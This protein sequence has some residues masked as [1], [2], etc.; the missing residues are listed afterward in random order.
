MTNLKI[1]SALALTS[2]L[3]ACGGEADRKTPDVVVPT[4]TPTEVP[5]PTEPPVSGDHI[6]FA[7]DFTVSSTVD[8]YDRA[9]KELTGDYPEEEDQF[10]FSTGGV[11]KDGELDPTGGNWITADN[12]QS[13]RLGN[14]RFSIAQPA[15]EPGDAR[16][17]TS[18]ATDTSTW[19]EL[20]LSQDYRLSFCVVAGSE[21]SSG[22][23]LFQLYIDNNSTSSSASIHGGASRV[24]NI[25]TAEFIPGKRVVINIPGDI[26]LDEDGTGDVVVV[27]NVGTASSFLQMRVSSGG[28]IV[29]DD[30]VLEYQSDTTLG[31]AQTGCDTKTTEWAEENPFVD[32]PEPTDVPSV[33]PTVT[34]TQPPVDG[35]VAWNIYDGAVSPLTDDSLTLADASTDKFGA[36]NAKPDG[37]EDFFTPNGDGTVA[38]LTPVDDIS[39]MARYVFEDFA[40]AD[41]PRYFTGLIRAKGVDSFKTM[42]F[43]LNLADG[44][45][46][47]R[48]KLILRADGSNQGVQV[49]KGDPAGEK[50]TAYTA[51][52]YTDY[53]IYQISVELTAAQEGTANVYLAGNDTPII[54]MTG[55]STTPFG[56]SKAGDNYVRIGDGS[57]SLLDYSSEVDWMIWT[58]EEAYVPSELKGKLPANIGDIPGYEDAAPSISWNVYDGTVSPLTD[59]SLT[60]ADASTDKFGASNAKPDGTEDFF[61]PNGDGTVAFLTPVDDISMMARYVFEDFAPTDY[62]RY[63]TGL[64][65]AKG[66]DSFK[67]MDFDLNLAD[68]TAGTRI[69]LI[70]RADGSNQG[71]QVDKGDPA[72]EK[73]TAYT[74][75][76]YTDYRIYQLSVELTAAQEGTANVYLAGSDTPIITM[77]GDATTPFGASKAGDNYVRIGDGSSSLLDYS[78]EVDWMIWTDE[79]AYLP[80]EL[81]GALPSAIG[82]T[83]G[84]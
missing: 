13:M 69:K 22:S 8:F 53:R 59:D 40:P 39:M 45:A 34:P 49:D 62:P 41:Y 37:T 32:A 19:G 67:T 48:I 70:L 25:S 10:Y 74:A 55:D 5:V 23:S 26:D 57:S 36:S 79:D 72:G 38:F 4:N 76:A 21:A 17:K 63:F 60:L 54:T 47:T 31:D 56:A 68:G 27:S 30:L 66:V 20:D 6:P 18:I 14:S 82:D 28:Y 80:S 83:T 64:I 46:G 43:D 75:E 3:A 29:L 11:F 50:P 12:D 84:Y 15:R 42:D 61:T 24:V 33:E 73:P 52:A 1:F 16:T 35:D 9:Y 78:S 65:R 81:S 44:T 77:T 51:E 2:I 7:E 71:V 58:D